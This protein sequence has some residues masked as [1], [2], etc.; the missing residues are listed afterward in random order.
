MMCICA[1]IVGVIILKQKW[2]L[3]SVVKGG[4]INS[5]CEE[6]ESTW[7]VFLTLTLSSSL[8]VSLCSV[9]SSPT[10]LTTSVDIWF[11]CVVS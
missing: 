11:R 9:V 3:K 7:Q 6:R 5:P 8:L 1:K 4:A 10:L 2:E